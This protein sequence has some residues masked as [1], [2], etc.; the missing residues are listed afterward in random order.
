MRYALAI[1]AVMCTTPLLGCG[2]QEGGTLAPI[3]PPNGGS[4]QVASVV[5]TPSAIGVT[6]GDTLRL[7]ASTRDAAGSVLSGRVVA[8]SSDTPGAAS[9]S[10][11]GLVTALIPNASVRITALSEGA[12]GVANIVT[13][14]R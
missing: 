5:I 1:A 6:V 10:S 8:W 2:A 14:T 12:T 7:V 4:S 9:V 11:T 13:L 3:V